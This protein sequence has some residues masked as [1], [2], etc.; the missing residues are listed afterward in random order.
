M[1][2]VLIDTSVWSEHFRKPQPLLVAL[3]AD[4]LAA[5]HE[6]VVEELALGVSAQHLNVLDDIIGMGL[7]PTATLEEYLR[8]VSR[9][10]ITGR[11]IGCVDT[12]LLASCKLANAGL[13]T[14]DK[15][16]AAAAR[17]CGIEVVE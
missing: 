10:E 8:F 4:G 11:K 1:Q 14:R 9:F 15:H 6:L 5:S 13:Y 7:L 17:A 16:L 12:H 2:A 3:L